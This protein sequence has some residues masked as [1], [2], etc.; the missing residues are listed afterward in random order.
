MKT[1]RVN[2]GRWR[3]D[4]DQLNLAK[5]LFGPPGTHLARVWFYRLIDLPQKEWRRKGRYSNLTLMLYFRNNADAVY[6]CLKNQ[7]K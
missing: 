3:G 2:C 5:D 4:E 7:Q 1:T 6:F